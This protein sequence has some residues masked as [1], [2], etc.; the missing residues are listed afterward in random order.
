MYGVVNQSIKGFVEDNHGAE[1]WRKLHTAAGA[2]ESFVAMSPYD[3][4]ITYNLVGAASEMLKVPMETILKAFGEYWVDKIAVVHYAEIMNRSGQNFV[5]FVKNLDHM[6]QRIRVA[7]PNY[8]PPSFR[9]KVLSVGRMQ[10]DYYSDRAGLLPFVEGL[11]VALGR[12]FKVSVAIEHLDA[13]QLGLP[14]KR[15][16]VDHAPI[17]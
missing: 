3:D 9:V 13:E 11:F 17:A 5:D 12:Y 16:L 15:F 7:F 6:H 4:S 10:V 14:C 2:P 8:N 1:V